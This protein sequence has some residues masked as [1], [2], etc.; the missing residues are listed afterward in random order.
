MGLAE[1]R[2]LRVEL[3]AQ[4]RVLKRGGGVIGG[5]RQQQL[6]DLARKVGTTARRSDQTDFRIDTY[7][8]RHTATW[9]RAAKVS[10]DFLTGKRIA[11]LETSPQPV[12]E[13]FPCAS[14]GHFDR[15]ASFGVAQ[16]H[17]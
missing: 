2:H 16:T 3:M 4:P 14:A 5:H 17:E 13:G 10:H 6:I 7:G 1:L 15:D 11:A 8:N 12:R 9:L